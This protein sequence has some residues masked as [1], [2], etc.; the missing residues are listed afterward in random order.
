MYSI[1]TISD[2]LHHMFPTLDHLVLPQLRD[3][4]VE[5]CKEFNISI[6]EMKWQ[7]LIIPQFQQLG[8]TKPILFD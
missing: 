7:D 2:T 6:R 1:F 4:L 3:I 8:R 5:T